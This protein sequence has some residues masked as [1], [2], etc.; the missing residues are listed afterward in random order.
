MSAYKVGI[1]SGG[2]F[3][4][5]MAISIA[6]TAETNNI[7][8]NQV[9]ILL[10]KEFYNSVSLVDLINKD[11]ENKKYLPNVKIPDNVVATINKDEVEDWDIVIFATPHEY[12]IKVCEEIRVKKGALLISLTK[13]FVDTNLTTPC[14]FLRK[15]YNEKVFSFMGANIASDIANKTFSQSTVGYDEDGKKEVACIILPLFSR[16]IAV[17]MVNDVV[18]VELCGALKNIVAVVYG[19]AEG[20]EL[21][22]NI[23]SSIFNEGIRETRLLLKENNRCPDLIFESCGIQDI[24]VTCL[25]GRNKKCGIMIAKE[26]KLGNFTSQGIG[27]CLELYKYLVKINSHLNYPIVCRLYDILTKKDLDLKKAIFDIF[28]R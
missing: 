23:L 20:L 2:S 7:F 12:F 27:T 10:N 13:G 16:H 25:A 3:G 6:E 21:G 11:K 5:S 15:K 9:S 26:K 22:P 28:L 8:K 19:I 24:F 17:S 14:T 18:G 1:V 4:T